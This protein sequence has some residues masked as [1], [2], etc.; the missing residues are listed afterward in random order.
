MSALAIITSSVCPSLAVK[1][2]P[3]RGL[4]GVGEVV[5]AIYEKIN[6]PKQGSRIP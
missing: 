5:S 1:D 4:K 2:Y 3:A 6:S